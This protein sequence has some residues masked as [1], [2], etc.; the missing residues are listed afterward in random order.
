[1]GFL[2]PVT[3]LG[4][5]WI[6]PHDIEVLAEPAPGAA[7]ATVRRLQRVG[8]EVRAELSTD[9][10]EP[11]VQLTRGEADDLGLVESGTVWLRPH[12]RATLLTAS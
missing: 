2:G 9:G 8:F 11:W 1:M 5:H 7:E 3:R 10:S 12:R 6:R 4:D